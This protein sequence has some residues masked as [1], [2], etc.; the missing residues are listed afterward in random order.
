MSHFRDICFDE[1]HNAKVFFLIVADAP[2]MFCIKSYRKGPVGTLVAIETPI[3]WSLLG[4]SLSPSLRTN[5]KMT[6]VIK[7]DCNIEQFN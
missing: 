2:K 6:F 5:C 7:G 4:Q 3:G 1:L